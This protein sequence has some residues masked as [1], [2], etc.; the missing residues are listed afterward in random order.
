MLLGTYYYAGI[1]YQDLPLRSVVGHSAVC[2]VTNHCIPVSWLDT[3]GRAC[4]T[5]SQTGYVG[6]GGRVEVV[7]F[8]GQGLAVSWFLLQP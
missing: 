7:G 4:T 2:G 8:K 1:I 6:Y 3:I 5:M